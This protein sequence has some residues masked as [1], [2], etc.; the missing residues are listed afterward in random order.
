MQV[1]IMIYPDH[2]LCQVK[3][4]KY[5]LEAKVTANVT[6]FSVN[7]KLKKLPKCKSANLL[8]KAA[9]EVK[10]AIR[11]YDDPYED[12]DFSFECL[13]IERKIND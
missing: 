7:M 13:M 3:T 1:I 5:C 4:Q 6:L 11:K 2:V 8:K 9:A 10:K 12:R